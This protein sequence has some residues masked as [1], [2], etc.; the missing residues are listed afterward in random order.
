MIRRYELMEKKILRVKLAVYENF[1]KQ[2][3]S[4]PSKNN[5]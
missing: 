1:N 4:I 5:L 3:L 2:I